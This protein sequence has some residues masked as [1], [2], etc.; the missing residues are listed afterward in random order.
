VAVLQLALA[1]GIF[2]SPVLFTEFDVS[3]QIMA[4]LFFK[5]LG[6]RAVGLFQSGV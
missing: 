6:R 5:L 3:P 1:Q 2:P 4:E